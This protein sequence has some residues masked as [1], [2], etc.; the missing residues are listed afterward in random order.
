M[1]IVA[2]IFK[3]LNFFIFKVGIHDYFTLHLKNSDRLLMYLLRPGFDA[4]LYHETW[5]GETQSPVI[6]EKG[7]MAKEVTI[8]PYIARKRGHNIDSNSNYRQSGKKCAS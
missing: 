6:L 1:C 3:Y 4:F 5:P 8:I 7:I 2:P